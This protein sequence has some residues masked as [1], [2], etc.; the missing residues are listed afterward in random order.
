[1]LANVVNSRDVGSKHASWPTDTINGIGHCRRNGGK[2]DVG[3][4]DT[5]GDIWKC[6]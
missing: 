6:P 5:A 2:E 3:H 1:M 4:A